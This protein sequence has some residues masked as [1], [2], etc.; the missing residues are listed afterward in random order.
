MCVVCD[1]PCLIYELVH[2]HCLGWY[3]GLSKLSTNTSYYRPGSLGR[4]VEW[5]WWGAPEE[6]GGG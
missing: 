6:T 2:V 4:G 3:L 1:G 5:V